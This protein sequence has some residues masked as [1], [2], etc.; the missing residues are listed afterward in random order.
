LILVARQVLIWGL[1]VDAIF[2]DGAAKL[3]SRAAPSARIEPQIMFLTELRAVLNSAT[4]K[5]T[6]RVMINMKNLARRT[7]SERL[8]CRRIL[9]GLTVLTI[10]SSLMACQVPV[11]RYALERWSSD[12]Y[13][14][15]VLAEGP[16]NLEHQ[17]T[18]KT[19]EGTAERPAQATMKVHDV[20]TTKDAFVK[21]LW[22][23]RQ[24]GSEP[25]MVVLY[26]ERSSINAEQ[27]AYS[28]PLSAQH[29][30][31]IVSSPARKEITEK[32]SEGHSAVWIFLESG[33][34]AKDQA[35]LTRL[36]E[37]LK[38]DAE[39]LKL[40][41]PEEMEIKPELLASA[42]IRLQIQFSVISVRRDDL[43]E[44][45]LIDCLLNSESDLREYDEPMAFP[46]FGRG[47]V[48]YA[49][50]GQGIAADTI[51]K[52][53]SFIVGPCSCQVKEQNPGF[54]LL[55]SC[56]WDDLVGD[57]FIS[58]PIPEG[59]SEPKLLTIPA[60]RAKP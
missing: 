21:Q 59:E 45:F 17:T 47:R 2:A 52:A 8:H 58:E 23:S 18:L 11:F 3:R 5:L 27:V 22:K 54:D 36:Q 46:V 49:I 10:A 16:L 29:V 51:R 39:W 55:L 41:S 48:L 7:L 40:P 34:A 20:T 53:S 1:T 43:K 25:L 37:Q 50:V 35:A 44:Q 14:I 32:L 13:R 33:D 30:P 57:T 26:P 28:S 12:Q 60:G 15:L 6:L 31:Q 56:N 19:L 24:T 9:A 42:K 4:S 38:K